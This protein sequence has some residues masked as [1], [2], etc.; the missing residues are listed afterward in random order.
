[1][2]V[3]I[4]VYER[5]CDMFSIVSWCLVG[6]LVSDVVVTRAPWL[7]GPCSERSALRAGSCSRRSGLQ[8]SGEPS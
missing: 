5:L 2:A 1:M 7:P 8:I 4:I 6:W 3:A